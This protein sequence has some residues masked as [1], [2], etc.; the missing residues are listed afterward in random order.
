MNGFSTGSKI[1]MYLQ[2]MKLIFYRI[3][4]SSLG[5]NKTFAADSCKQIKENGCNIVKPKSGVYWVWK[6]QPMQVHVATL[7]MYTWCYLFIK[8]ILD[9]L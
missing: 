1:N 7:Y 4:G 9:L 6:K 3:D 5:R 8:R 2:I